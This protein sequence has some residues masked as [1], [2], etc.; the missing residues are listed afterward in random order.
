MSRIALHDADKNDFPNLALMKLSS[1]HKLLGDTV[2]W[3]VPGG[4]YDLVYS[5]KVFTFTPADPML[6]VNTIYGGTGYNIAAVLPP[7][8][9]ACYPD[10]SLYGITYGLGFLTRGCI[11]RCPECFVPEKE[12]NI[13][14]ESDITSFLQGNSAVLMDNNV[15]AH[16]H[17]VAQIEKI[18]R[19]GIKVDFNQGLDAR[20]ID[21]PMA[22]LLSKVNWLTPL[23]LACDSPAMMGPVRRAV[24]LLRWYDCT[25]R[26]Y[27]CYLL[28]RDVAEALERAKFL[29]GIYVDAFAQPYIPP[30]GTQP[31]IEQR[32]FARWVNSK[33]LFK[34]QWWEDYKAERGP[35]RV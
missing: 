2:E 3:F 25:P 17:G 20:L 27:F 22:R 34:G 5:S 1:W 24:E 28:V 21:D 13:R 35:D 4:Q 7:H 18:I 31:S 26:Q 9:N 16:P 6:P 23:R 8:I 14:A 33:M 19:L 11:R 30:D 12:G 32:Q 10:Y 15:L 29:K